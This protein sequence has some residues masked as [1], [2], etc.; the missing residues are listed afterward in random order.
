MDLY[1]SLV[2]CIFHIYLFHLL[3]TTYY[4]FLLN[5]RYNLNCFHHW[6]YIIIFLKVRRG[7]PYCKFF[8][9]TVKLQHIVCTIDKYAHGNFNYDCH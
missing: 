9:I 1:N 4:L 3:E 8:I 5:R 6:V 7:D 2:N